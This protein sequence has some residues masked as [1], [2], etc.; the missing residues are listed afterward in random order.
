V[1]DELYR[2]SKEAEMVCFKELL[3][4]ILGGMEKNY[5]NVSQGSRSPDRYLNPVP[6]KYKQKNET[7][8]HT[9]D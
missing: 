5:R 1:N 8:G 7:F 6:F 4:H 3:Q 2:I 9:F